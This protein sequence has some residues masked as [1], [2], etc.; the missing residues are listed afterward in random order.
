MSRNEH[1]SRTPL[2]LLQRLRGG[3]TDPAAWDE[4]ADRYGSKIYGWCCRWG[5]QDAD[6][7]DVTQTVLLALVRQMK[8]FAYDGNG[9][10][11]AWLKTVSQRAWGKFLEKQAR[12][13]RGTGDSAALDQLHSLPA[14]DDLVQQIEEESDRELFQLALE[15][16]RQRVQ[17]QTLEAFRL[18]ALENVSGAEVARRLGMRIGAVYMAKSNVQKLLREEIRRF[19]PNA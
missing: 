15:R 2:T 6:A 13:G 12:G 3:G 18:L 11:R 9:S 4:F 17:P 8:D 19:E 14:R 10:F 1:D 5:L 16:V 7:R